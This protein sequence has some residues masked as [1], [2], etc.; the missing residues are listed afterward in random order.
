MEANQILKT[1]RQVKAGD[2]LYRMFVNASV[3]DFH[4]DVEEFVAED[5]ITQYPATGLKLYIHYRDNSGD[6]SV[7][8]KGVM[9][10]Y[11]DDAWTI[12]R[13]DGGCYFIEAPS[14]E[15]LEEGWDEIWRNYIDMNM[16]IRTSIGYAREQNAK[17]D[18]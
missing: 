10:G 5:Y 16:N 12:D 14:I 4:P 2:P 18:F 1:F 7:P 15:G 13:H 11:P 9:T 17:K 8:L 6:G 3:T